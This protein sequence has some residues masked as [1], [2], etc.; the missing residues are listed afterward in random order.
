M[1][2]QQMI[3]SRGT[4]K[5]TSKY[6]NKK[7]VIDGIKFDS[8]KESLRYQQLK[9]LEQEGLIKNLELQKEFPLQPSFKKNGKTYRKISYIADFYYYDNHLK[10]YVVED[11]KASKSFQTDVYKMKKKMFE[12]KYRSLELTEI[13]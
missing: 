4:T 9:L 3:L 13:I 12:Y 1:I 11:V 2:R 6:H 5:T 10:H 7:V 8:K